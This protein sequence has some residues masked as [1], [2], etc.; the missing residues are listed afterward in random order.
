MI[1]GR[2]IQLLL[3]KLG[4]H[5]VQSFVQIHEQ[6]VE[7]IRFAFG[8]RGE[9]VDDTTVGQVF[10]GCDNWASMRSSRSAN[11]TRRPWSSQHGAAIR[12]RS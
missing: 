5:G 2:A 11:S 8:R 10:L 12:R 7:A 9:I 3:S 4:L 6:A 1:N